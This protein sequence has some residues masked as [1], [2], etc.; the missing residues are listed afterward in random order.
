MGVKGK[1]IKSISS[2]ANHSAL[3]TTEG[4][5]FICGSYLHGKLGLP[6]LRQDMVKKFTPLT[7]LRQKRII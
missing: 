1:L 6:E 4:E 7:L 5:I 2:G 3:V